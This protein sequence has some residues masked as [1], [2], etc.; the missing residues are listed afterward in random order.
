MTK[1]LPA[2]S[3]NE[4]QSL[5]AFDLDEKVKTSGCIDLS[6]YLPKGKYDINYVIAL[7]KI[8]H[9]NCQTTPMSDLGFTLSESLRRLIGMLEIERNQP[10]N[11]WI[12]LYCQE[13]DLN[14]I[15]HVS[16]AKDWKCPAGCGLKE[17]KSNG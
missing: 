6:I 7:C 10:K 5:S 11:G 9:G 4:K 17:E 12:V 3:K 8:I 1:N 15:V 13:C 14:D 2:I 16:D